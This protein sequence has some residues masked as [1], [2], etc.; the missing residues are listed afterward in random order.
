M[1]RMSMYL[2]YLVFSLLETVYDSQSIAPVCHCNKQCHCATQSPTTPS[3]VSRLSCCYKP[4]LVPSILD[5]CPSIQFLVPAWDCLKIKL[6]PWICVITHTHTQT[7]ASSHFLSLSCFLFFFF[8]HTQPSGLL[9]PQRQVCRE[10]RGQ[11]QRIKTMRAS[12]FP[13]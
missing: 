11:R 8:F 3:F 12:Y 2:Q 10:A 4:P 1:N 13:S 6:V 5:L 7:H 9:R